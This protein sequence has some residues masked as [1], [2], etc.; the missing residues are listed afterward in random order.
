MLS[1][2]VMSMVW[3]RA[4]KNSLHLFHEHGDRRLKND[5]CEA[6]QCR[7]ECVLCFSCCHSLPATLS[8]QPI[9][10]YPMMMTMMLACPPPPTACASSSHNSHCSQAHI[11]LYAKWTLLVH[12]WSGEASGTIRARM[13][14]K[15]SRLRQ[16]II[17]F[18]YSWRIED[19][20][21]SDDV[22]TINI[23]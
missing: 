23:Y 13:D 17:N 8:T 22:D 9:F 3:E 21:H 18:T 15:T 20:R 1:F 14:E 10:H 7:K 16:K 4:T 6:F 19:R 5:K 11:Y 12:P 2:H